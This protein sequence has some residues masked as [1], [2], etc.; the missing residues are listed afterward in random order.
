MRRRIVTRNYNAI[1]GVPAGIID[2]FQ[3]VEVPIDKMREEFAPKDKRRLP[4]MVTRASRPIAECRL[5]KYGMS[6][7][8]CP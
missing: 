1:V 5:F 7:F 2:Q 6:R 3:G 8:T 4:S